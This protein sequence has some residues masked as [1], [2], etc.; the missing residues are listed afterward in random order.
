MNVFRDKIYSFKGAIPVTSCTSK[1]VIS[2]QF[3]LRVECIHN[4]VLHFTS[5]VKVT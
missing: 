3:F 2:E 4:M 1:A 5:G